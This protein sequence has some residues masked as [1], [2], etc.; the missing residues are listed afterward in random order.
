[1]VKLWKNAMI[2][3]ERLKFFLKFFF[4]FLGSGSLGG[5]SFVEG[6]NILGNIKIYWKSVSVKNLPKTHFGEI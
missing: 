2:I 5:R 3:F 4:V 1:M 6:E